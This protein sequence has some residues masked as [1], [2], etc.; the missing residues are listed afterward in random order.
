MRR[1]VTL[2]LF[3]SLSGPALAADDS[4]ALLAEQRDAAQR[5]RQELA[6]R[7]DALAAQL[8]ET[9]RLLKL[10]DAYLER[11]AEELARQR[12]TADEPTE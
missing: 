6:E 4:E 1:A 9:Q 12:E 11:L 8:A 3:A 5:E 2:L 7:T 10:Q